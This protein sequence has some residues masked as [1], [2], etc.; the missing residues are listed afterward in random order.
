M[1]MVLTSSMRPLDAPGNV[2]LTRKQSG[3][4]KDSV[5]NV[6][7][8]VTLDRADLRERVGRVPRAF[9]LRVDDGLRLVLD[10]GEST[11]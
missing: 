4:P 9:M 6:S 7:Q 3:L 8:L 10:L 1:A 11:A 5:A 2:L